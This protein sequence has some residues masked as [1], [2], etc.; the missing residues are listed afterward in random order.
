MIKYSIRFWTERCWIVS[1]TNLETNKNMVA[2]KLTQEKKLYDFQCP[3]L[4]LLING[5]SRYGYNYSFL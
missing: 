3:N 1:T 4:F 2:D 5:G